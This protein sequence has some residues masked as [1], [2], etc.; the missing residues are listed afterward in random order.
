[1]LNDRRANDASS[2]CIVRFGAC[3]MTTFV[4]AHSALTHLGEDGCIAALPAEKLRD[5]GPQKPQDPKR[6]QN[7]AITDCGGAQSLH[8]MC[9]SKYVP[10]VIDE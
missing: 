4:R 3:C 2:D 5:S 7:L 1:M 10:I 6:P 8:S 9:S